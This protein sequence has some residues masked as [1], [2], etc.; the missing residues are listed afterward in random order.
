[1]IILR[2]RLGYINQK[3]SLYARFKM[4]M[5]IPG[6]DSP[7]LGTNQ[8]RHESILF[9]C[10]CIEGSFISLLPTSQRRFKKRR[11]ADDRKQKDQESI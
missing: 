7:P 8:Y 10:N 1:M 3:D 9:T 4:I 6:I 5:M 11:T 2:N